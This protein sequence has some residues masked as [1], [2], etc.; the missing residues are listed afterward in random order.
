MEVGA[1]VSAETHKRTAELEQLL[2]V[3]STTFYK[4]IEF[5][6]IE[7]IKDDEKL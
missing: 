4:D 7:V 6:N 3:K 5:L 1:E 2:G